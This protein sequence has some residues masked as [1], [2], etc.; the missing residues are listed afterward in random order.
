LYLIEITGGFCFLVFRPQLLG[1]SLRWGTG[2]SHS[3]AR[4][5]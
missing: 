3:D 1:A 4:E 5:S 2:K